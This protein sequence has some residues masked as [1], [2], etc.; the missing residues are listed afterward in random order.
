LQS[1]KAAL[2]DRK[3]KFTEQRLAE[4]VASSS[5]LADTNKSERLQKSPAL[6]YKSKSPS[7][8]PLKSVSRS[9]SGQKSRKGVEDS[10]T[11]GGV[12]SVRVSE[13]KRR[14]STRS[15][16]EKSTSPSPVG[17]TKVKGTNRSFSGRTVGIG[18]EGGNLRKDG[19]EL[20]PVKSLKGLGNQLNE[21]PT[22]SLGKKKAGNVAR[23]EGKK[24]GERRVAERKEENDN[25]KEIIARNLKYDYN[26]TNDNKRKE[27]KKEVGKFKKL[28]ELYN[29]MNRNSSQ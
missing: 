2:V 28:E 4:S 13:S 22:F 15:D 21:T 26:F 25:S 7:Q 20:R 24:E 1:I 27:G 23:K 16:R 9:V 14:V 5:Q 11:K 29:E 12:S 19:K 18:K 3:K 6:S 10:E 17:K 8:S